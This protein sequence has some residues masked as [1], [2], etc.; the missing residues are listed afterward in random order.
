MSCHLKCFQTVNE[1]TP[2]MHDFI[3]EFYN[4]KFYVVPLVVYEMK[5]NL[6]TLMQASW[7]FIFLETMCT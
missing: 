5:W 1:T 7:S 6:L 3:L 2:K 4:T